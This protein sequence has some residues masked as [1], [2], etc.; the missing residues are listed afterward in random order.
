MKMIKFS[1]EMKI[2][3]LIGRYCEYF[4]L[5][6]SRRKRGTIVGVSSSI[7]SNGFVTSYMIHIANKSTKIVERVPE[8]K[9]ITIIDGEI[10][11]KEHK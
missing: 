4:N 6:S 7:K 9:F 3:E 5:E 10:Y 2:N 11:L 1:S 8:N